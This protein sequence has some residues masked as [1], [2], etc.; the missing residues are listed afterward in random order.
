MSR[1]KFVI[2]TRLVGNPHLVDQQNDRITKNIRQVE[3]GREDCWM[4]FLF[5]LPFKFESDDLESIHC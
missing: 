2:Q 3:S 1:N 4:K 5:T